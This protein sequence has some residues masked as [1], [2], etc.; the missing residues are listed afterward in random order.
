MSCNLKLLFVSKTGFITKI[1][2]RDLTYLQTT[3]I[4]SCFFFRNF[5]FRLVV[6]VRI[7]L[8]VKVHSIF[9]FVLH[10]LSES[11]VLT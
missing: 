3:S 10:N 5:M 7:D 1:I 4:M 6:F 2:T 8:L 11:P 9:F